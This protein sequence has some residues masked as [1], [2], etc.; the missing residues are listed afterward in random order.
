MALTKQTVRMSITEGIDTKTDE[1]N[2]I[3]TKFLVA[4]NVVFTKTGSASKRNG[5]TRTSKLVLDGSPLTSTNAVT[6]F[7][8]ELLSY[9]PEAVYTFSESQ[10]KWVD[11]GTVP[12]A[13]SSAT[14]VDNT[15]Y[16]LTVPAVAITQNLACYAYEENVGSVRTRYSIIDN[17]TG[18]TVHSGTI[19]AASSPKVLVIQG[20]FFIFTIEAG[21]I[22]AR[23]INYGTPTAIGTPIAVATILGAEYDVQAIGLRAYFAAPRTAGTGTNIG[24]LNIDGT[25]S[26]LTLVPSA[27]QV[28]RTSI[29]E[30]STGLVRFCYGSTGE[31]AVHSVLY[32]ADLASTIHAA[33][34]IATTQEYTAISSVRS[35]LNTDT[36]DI[37]L[38]RAAVGGTPANICKTNI[39]ASGTNTAIASIFSGA[40]LHSKVAS[41]G[42]K[43]YFAMTH[44]GSLGYNNADTIYIASEDSEFITK[45][46]PSQCPRLTDSNLTPLILLGDSLNFA[47]AVISEFQVS[48]QNLT[49]PTTIK[50]MTADFSQL[51][52][53]FDT[54]LG[55]NLH[56]VG[57]VLK[58]YDGNRIVEHG[59][60]DI[61][62]APEYVSETTTGAI[63][64]VGVYQY[65]I[66][67][68]WK[69][70]SGQLHRSAPSVPY[71]YT[72]VSVPKKPTILVKNLF[73]TQKSNV[74][75]EVYR[76]EVNGTV[77]YKHKAGV[78]DIIVNDPT[79]TSQYFTD[80][81]SDADLISNEALYT[82]G[83]VLD[84]ISAESSKYITSYKNR[85]F[86][87]SA[88][89]TY[90]QYS[91]IRQ[92]NGPVEFNDAL[93]IKLDNRGGKATA[94]AVMDDHLIIFKENAIFTISGDGPNDLGE[95]DD[96]RLPFLSTSDTGCLDLNSVAISPMGV[97]F[98]SRKG[99]YLLGRDFNV[100]YIGAAV[101]AYNSIT[102]TSATLVPK[103]NQIRFTTSSDEALV[104]DYFHDM[105]STFSNINAID[106]TVYK[107]Q[108][109]FARTNADIM[110]ETEGVFT[111]AGSFIP[112]TLA[113]A[114]ISFGGATANG[115]IAAGL[116][117]F[118]R[119]YKMLILG[120]YKNSCK[121]KVSLGFD[122]NS[123]YVSET[124][125]NAG[126]I[127]DT[128]VYGT[129]TYGS[130][131]P[132]GGED[133]LFQWRIFP[134][135]Q[136]CETFRFKIEDINSGV[137][138]ESF[139][140]SNFAAEVGLK[141]GLYKKSDANSSGTNK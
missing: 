122:F 22:K 9:T 101:E 35:P 139:S 1:K 119:F 48:G 55:D 68:A 78:L 37:F 36:S 52:N 124:T 85:I 114:W 31:T 32:I 65:V 59:F 77:F 84:N 16:R 5:H 109:T 103:T 10:N 137:P 81:I 45:Y 100:K 86:L 7:K 130:G 70:K 117:G 131:T 67:Y 132:Y 34:S 88:D 8:D 94:L 120:T 38:S 133:P 26:G 127:L 62:D 60:L 97:M 104:Y 39:D 47:A 72:V 66:V 96:F 11:K 58:M 41:Y 76:T 108:Y 61:P 92:Q 95:Q 141:S 42:T 129:G 138:G 20:S 40:K 136:K 13:L 44:D 69:D 33:V 21:A 102:I 51:N 2:V 121:F 4:D 46:D 30:E 98:K 71:T 73:F 126:T 140:I 57:G 3:A 50:K 6:T 25:V 54:E 75:I 135:R 125:I 28:T 14:P 80:T 123:A 105:W 93:K 53:Y 111:D 63:L 79:T 83:G 118:E 43:Q 134:A 87:I 91:K 24:W 115:A 29:S 89:G 82:T 110:Q 128:P 74:E 90:L 113:S 27:S 49:V 15:N 23:R 17:T 64:P 19:A 106:A 112:M 18:T 116:Q 56:V 99:I 107:S 12:I